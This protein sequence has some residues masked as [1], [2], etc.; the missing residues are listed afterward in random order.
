MVLMQ[1]D[2]HEKAVHC[3]LFALRIH[4]LLLSEVRAHQMDG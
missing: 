3:M 1:P 2:S 4:L